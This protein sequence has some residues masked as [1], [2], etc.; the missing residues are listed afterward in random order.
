MVNVGQAP[1]PSP[2]DRATYT[3]Q[4]CTYQYEPGA[5]RAIPKKETIWL[6]TTSS[7]G[8]VG[9]QPIHLR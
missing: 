3:A 1:E 4:D 2:R 7:Q 9:L 8:L 6:A 5:R